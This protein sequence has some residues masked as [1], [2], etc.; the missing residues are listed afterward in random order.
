[1]KRA[2]PNTTIDPAVRCPTEP[3]RHDPVLSFIAAPAVSRLLVPRGAALVAAV[4]LAL[5]LGFSQRAAALDFEWVGGG[6]D[7]L[8]NN[9]G[10]WNQIVFPDA[11]DNIIL[12]GASAAGP[13]TIDVNGSREINRIEHQGVSGNYTIGE[14]I[15]GDTITIFQAG[16]NAL[17][18]QTTPIDAMTPSDLIINSNVLLNEDNV[19]LRF[20]GNDGSDTSGKIIVHGDVA[21]AAGATGFQTLVLTSTNKSGE[22]IVEVNGV[23][24]DGAG[25]AVLG[26][27]A[28]LEE[29]QSSTAITDHAGHVELSG[30][31]DFTGPV[32]VTGGTL[33]FDSIEN[34]GSLNANALGI[35][36]LAD[37]D[38]VI[39]D[40]NVHTG[41]LRYIGSG[42]TSD[43]LIAITSTSSNDSSSATID[44]S[45][46]GALVLSGGVAPTSSN[47]LRT[48]TLTGDNTDDNTISGVI[49][50]PA[51]GSGVLNVIKNGAGKWVL[52]ASNTYDGTT[53]V[54]AGE[55]VVEGP[56]GAIGTTTATIDVNP[57]GTLTV[58]GGT[59]TT[60]DLDVDSGA[61]FNFCFRL[62]DIGCR[63]L[64]CLSMRT[65]TLAPTREFRVLVRCRSR[66]VAARIT[67]SRGSR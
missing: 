28:G 61:T 9:A 63:A 44:A 52:S 26:I 43:R 51:G 47:N 1:M 21:P 24:S 7:N 12:T 58:D 18:N 37:S 15:G 40:N 36:L 6:G 3:R 39:G 55:L 46:S 13:I 49:E 35:P 25:G 20:N 67:R 41:T 42:H 33:V 31:N 38:I 59:V 16:G 8:W 60:N 5:A 48:L 17:L 50:M 66:Q 34:V 56:S 19:I 23:I 11:L 30:L 22:S 10:N 2:N 14:T 45:G 62:G 29:T 57:G 32:R 65:W 27:N 53:N 4:S 54:N 64:R